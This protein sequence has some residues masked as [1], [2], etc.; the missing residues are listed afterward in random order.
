MED[1]LKFTIKVELKEGSL[2]HDRLLELLYYSPDT[3]IFTWKISCGRVRN[4]QESG[5]VNC[6][7]YKKI[8]VDGKTYTAHR[9]AWFYIYKKW[10]NGDIDHIDNNRLNNKISNLREA[11]RS[12]NLQNKKMQSNNTSGYIGVSYD[13]ARDKWDARLKVFGKQICLGL[14]ET[15]E[16]ASKAYQ[17]KA[18]EYYKEFKF[19]R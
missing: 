2:S 10:P 12:Q 6:S 8:S 11:T 7:G 5:W 16:E 14:F 17:D 1:K 9:L 4:E 13:K 18:S 19:N 3:G 15:A